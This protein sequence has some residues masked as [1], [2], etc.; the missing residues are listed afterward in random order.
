[1]VHLNLAKSLAETGDE[2]AG[3]AL[4]AGRQARPD[5]AGRIG[6]LGVNFAGAR[7]AH[8]RAAG[9]RSGAGVDPT[10]AQATFG[11]GNVFLETGSLQ[12]PAPRS[13]GHR[14][15]STALFPRT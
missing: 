11:R 4:R 15:Q 8:D 12:P 7:P 1:M 13:K 9:V 3:A 2:P 5:I 14:D 6:T 10:L